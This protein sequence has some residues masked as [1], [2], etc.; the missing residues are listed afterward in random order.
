MKN[1]NV[2]KKNPINKPFDKE[3]KIS[4]FFVVFVLLSN[5]NFVITFV[6]MKRSHKLVWRRSVTGAETK[7]SSVYFFFLSWN[8]IVMNMKFNC[9]YLHK[10]DI[11]TDDEPSKCTHYVWCCSQRVLYNN[12][13]LNSCQFVSANSCK[14]SVSNLN[15]LSSSLLR[16]NTF[17]F[18]HD[19]NAYKQ[20]LN[21]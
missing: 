17:V 12:G 8:F 6:S 16:L 18:T 19:S 5:C 21:I 13:K 9:E 1:R 10:R 14:K 3:N 7:L 2:A 4:N 20:W 11:K 15:L